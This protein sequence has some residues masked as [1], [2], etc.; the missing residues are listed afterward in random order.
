MEKKRDKWYT[1]QDSNLRPSD[2]KSQDSV[3][4]S[5]ICLQETL[6]SFHLITSERIQRRPLGAQSA[7]IPSLH[8]QCGEISHSNQKKVVVISPYLVLLLLSQSTSS[9]WIALSKLKTG[10]P[11]SYI[12]TLLS[13]SLLDFPGRLSKGHNPKGSQPHLEQTTKRHP[14]F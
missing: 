13:R 8:S 4:G 3:S 12:R 2:S 14:S 7:H 11:K 5:F 6:K 9:I 10:S 1:R